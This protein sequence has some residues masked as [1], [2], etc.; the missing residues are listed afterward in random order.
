VLLV[1]VLLVLV[2]LLVVCRRLTRETAPL[3]SCT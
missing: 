2:L 3:S 1:L